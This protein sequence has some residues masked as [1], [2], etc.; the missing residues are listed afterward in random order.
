MR[1]RFTIR[2]LLWLI[3]LV[4][5]AVACWTEPTQAMPSSDNRI[6][7]FRLLAGLFAASAALF[8]RSLVRE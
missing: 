6:E 8:V 3:V 1:L 2:D 5:L 7:P 4:A